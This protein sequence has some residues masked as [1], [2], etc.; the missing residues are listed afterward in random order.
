MKTIL[1]VTLPFDEGVTKHEFIMP[2]KKLTFDE[3]SW[4]MVILDTLITCDLFMDQ[5]IK[6]IYKNRQI[7]E[8]STGYEIADTD[9]TLCTLPKVPA[10]SQDL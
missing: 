8:Y 5:K 6:E 9:D 4:I 1:K 10:Q 3:A 7:R 2:E